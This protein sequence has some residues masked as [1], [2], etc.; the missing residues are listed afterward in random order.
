MDQQ[1]PLL[2][3]TTNLSFDAI[4]QK[5]GTMDKKTFDTIMRTMFAPYVET[6]RKLCDLLQDTT[7]AFIVGDHGSR[8]SLLLI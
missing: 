7:S 2:Q 5:K 4:K 6:Q 1:I 8:H 3:A